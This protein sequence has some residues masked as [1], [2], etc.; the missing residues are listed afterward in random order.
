MRTIPRHRKRALRH[1]PRNSRGE[2]VIGA[3]WVP[4]VNADAD[5]YW[6]DPELQRIERE[7]AHDA[8][9]LL[10]RDLVESGEASP[11]EMSEYYNDER[12][13]RSVQRAIEILEHQAAR[14]QGNP[15]RRRRNAS[16]PDNSHPVEVVRHYRGGP[17]GYQPPFQKAIDRGAANQRAYANGLKVSTTTQLPRLAE[18]GLRLGKG[19]QQIKSDL[20]AT[21]RFTAA[22]IAAAIDKAKARAKNPGA[23]AKKTREIYEKFNGRPA[24]KNSTVRAPNGTPANVAK[25]GAL[26]L[27]KTADGRKWAF[28]GAKAPDLA[29]DHR[30]RL[31]VVGGSYRAN[32]AGTDHGEI[33]QIEYETKKPHLGQ[34]KQTIYYHKLGEE[35]G[36]R[37]KLK[38][39]REGL[40]RIIGG[41]YRIEADG[42]HD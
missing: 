41:D 18:M 9:F 39:D 20:S 36:R 33:V 37:P 14:R 32:P 19:I 13:R 15:R 22:G 42:I 38:I 31:H 24:R 2:W 29:A 11:L 4:G 27:I 6:G 10:L 30:G 40:I 23:K 7:L 16:S 26:R 12:P 3:D 1:N 28:N 21:G 34:P 25:L 8:R 5:E 35:G 17:A